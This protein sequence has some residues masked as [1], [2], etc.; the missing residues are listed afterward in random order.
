[1]KEKLPPFFAWIQ[2]QTHRTDA[3]GLLALGIACEDKGAEIRAE[4]AVI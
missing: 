3:V 4:E 1:M 2:E